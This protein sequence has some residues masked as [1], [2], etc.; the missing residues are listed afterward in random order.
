MTVGATV[1]AVGGGKKGKVGNDGGDVGV[2]VGLTRRG[3]LDD[4]EL[5]ESSAVESVETS[6]CSLVVTLEEAL[7]NPRGNRRSWRRWKLCQMICWTR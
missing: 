1:A 2:D 7:W 6:D 3:L 5:V 4:G